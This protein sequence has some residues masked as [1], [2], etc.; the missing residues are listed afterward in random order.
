MSIDERQRNNPNFELHASRQ[1]LPSSHSDYFD[2]LKL[3]WTGITQTP[4]TFHRNSKV[5]VYESS[6]ADLSPRVMSSESIGCT[7]YNQ[8][9]EDVNLF[10][11]DLEDI[12]DQEFRWDCN[13]PFCGRVFDCESA[14]K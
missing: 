1:N 11:V 2:L 13:F 9:V 14:Y 12:V 4:E 6:A 10:G 7:L 3:A 5:N 8:P